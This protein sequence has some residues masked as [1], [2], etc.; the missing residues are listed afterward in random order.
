MGDE[1]GPHSAS[2]AVWKQ[3]VCSGDHSRELIRAT[4]RGS[5]QIHHCFLDWLLEMLNCGTESRKKPLGAAPVA[6]R[7]AWQAAS[8]SRDK[9]RLTWWAT[10]HLSESHPVL[11]SELQES[12][13]VCWTQGSIWPHIAQAQ[14]VQPLGGREK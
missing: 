5:R 13:V 10:N 1:A 2:P 12:R 8:S 6:S 3:D 7:S 14:R 9:P 11:P 4:E